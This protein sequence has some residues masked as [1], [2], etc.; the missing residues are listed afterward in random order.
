MFLLISFP[1]ILL[2]CVFY[3]IAFSSDYERKSLANIGFLLSIACGGTL[4]AIFMKIV[5][6]NCII[7]NLENKC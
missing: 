7:T 3:F 4:I 2:S 5:T 1:L 6:K